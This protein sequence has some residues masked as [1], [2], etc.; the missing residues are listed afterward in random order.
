MTNDDKF[1]IQ[2]I[3]VGEIKVLKIVLAYSSI[4]DMFGFVL[5]IISRKITI[6]LIQQ[7][8]YMSRWLAI[9]N[10]MYIK[11]AFI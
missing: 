11:L 5:A 1:K 10:D 8:I 9:R 7:I 2:Q 4:I 3:A 6:L